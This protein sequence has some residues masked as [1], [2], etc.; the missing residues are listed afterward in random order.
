MNTRLTFLSHFVLCLA[1]SAGAFFAWTNGVFTTIWT[2]DL[3]RMTSVIA[4]LFVG[5]AL[6]LGLQA[7]RTDASSPPTPL[8]HA[9]EG[10]PHE[11]AQSKAGDASFGHLAE[12]LCV[13]T[14]FV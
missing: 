2:N 3:S 10:K 5:S 9:G 13:M 7:W 14:G 4:C 6:Y 12:R 8:T 1:I 11:A